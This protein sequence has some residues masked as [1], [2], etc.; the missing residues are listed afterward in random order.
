MKF[1]CAFR[2]ID[3]GIDIREEHP[4]DNPLTG[5]VYLELS[6]VQANH[7]LDRHAWFAE[8]HARNSDLLNLTLDIR[9]NH[10]LRLI[11]PTEAL[12]DA[13]RHGRIGNSKLARLSDDFDIDNLPTKAEDPVEAAKERAA[14]MRDLTHA[15]VDLVVQTNGV[16]YQIFL[17]DIQYTVES[18]TFERSVLE[19]AAGMPSPVAPQENDG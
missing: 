2:P 12:E 6:Q 18:A 17:P 13:W 5:W 15:A 3:P 1:L 16:W 7:M 9:N 14:R 11:K 10:G 4:T 19:E 8:L